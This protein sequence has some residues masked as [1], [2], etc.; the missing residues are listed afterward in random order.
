MTN[1]YELNRSV[2]TKT[3]KVTKPSRR[4][5]KAMA[6]PLD[7]SI[8]FEMT[9]EDCYSV[10]GGFFVGVDFSADFCANVLTKALGFVNNNV[11]GTTIV[12]ALMMAAPLAYAVILNT[13]KDLTDIL[14]LVFMA[15][16]PL[17][18]AL[19]IVGG[20]AA[21]LLAGC[22]V[23][24]SRGNNFKIGVEIGWFSVKGVFEI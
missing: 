24:G 14:S 7:D 17:K 21:A 15:Y 8:G 23:A 9:Y 12:N 22:I 3:S 18:V 11:W 10:N 6:Q 16:P 20:C 5:R 13:I 19:G 4:A 2:F 1:I